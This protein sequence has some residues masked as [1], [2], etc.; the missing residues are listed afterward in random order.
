[1]LLY[2]A[3]RLVTCSGSGSGSG[4]GRGSSSGVKSEMPRN[5]NQFVHLYTIE[6]INTI[7]T[8]CTF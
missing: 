8:T 3:I 1:M 6:I 5:S 4:S 7:I 2:L